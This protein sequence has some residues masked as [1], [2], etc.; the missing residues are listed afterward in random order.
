MSQRERNAAIL[1]IHCPDQPGLV[2]AVTQFIRAHGGNIL[3]LDQHTDLEHGR[4]FMR[5]AWDLAGFDLPRE[6]IGARF[7]EAVAAR[8]GMRWELFFSDQ[9]LRM[10]I[11]VSRQFHCL[12]DL[13]A[14]YHAGEWPNVEIPLIISNHPDVTDIAKRFELACHVLPVTA[15]NKARQEAEQL[16][17]LEA[18]G[19]DFIVLARYMQILSPQFVARFPNRIINIHHSFLP[20][21]PGAR[22][23]HSAWARGVKVIGATS[24]YVTAELDA[25]P[26][27]EQDVVRVTHKDTVA[28]LVRKGRDLEKLVLARAVW[29]HLQ[30]EILVFENRTVVFA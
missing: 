7:D 4:F 2:A 17:L 18:H 19:I 8:F 21:F 24:H 29:H 26:I 27:I 20:A 25:G 13:L 14:R 30:R 22:P 5:V 9:K 10:A 16:R 1:L 12:F 15:Q 3:D 11:F 23:Y 6:A 28:D